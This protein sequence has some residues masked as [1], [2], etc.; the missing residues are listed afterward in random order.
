MALV[1]RLRTS[2]TAMTEA[3][4]VLAHPDR[5]VRQWPDGEPKR[6]GQ[7]DHA[8]GPT[9]G[10]PERAASIPLTPRYRGD[11]RKDDLFGEGAE[12]YGEAE[13]R[14]HDARQRNTHEREREVNDHDGCQW[15]DGPQDVHGDRH[16]D[17]HRPITEASK[18]GEGDAECRA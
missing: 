6:L 10:E 3:S 13:P 12:N 15:R 4:A 14:C 1:A 17:V 18:C 8:Q 2:G 9:E 16:C 5:A 11:G 7:H